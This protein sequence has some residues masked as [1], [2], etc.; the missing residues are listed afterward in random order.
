MKR[1]RNILVPLHFTKAD[2]AVVR[3]VS[4]FAAWCSPSSITFCHYSPREEI[5]E[6]LKES[7]PWLWEPIDEAALERLRKEVLGSGLFEDE[8]ILRF[9]VEEANPVSRSLERVLADDCDLVVTGGERRD[10]AVRLARKAPCSVC[11]VPAGSAENIR[12]AAVAVDFSH[13][14]R[15]ACEIGRALSDAMGSEEPV[16]LHVS[17]LHHGHRLGL[18]SS[19]ELI[20]A[21]ERHAR[22]R[23]RDFCLGLDAP[24]DP[25]RV[26]VHHHESV[27]Y[28]ILDYVSNN[29]I[30]C[31]VIGCR[32]RD[33]LSA[34]LLGSVAEEILTHANVPVLAVKTKGT[35]QGFLKTILGIDD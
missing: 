11:V 14:S 35:G 33:A 30:D 2:D 5:P 4:H 15:Y 23:L 32:G 7:H 1:F 22:L 21:N 31:L 12:R 28:G 16:L 29:G 20:A 9:E 18:L 19:E 25:E 34:L 27:A 8:S 10:I 13:Y 3:M 26:A 6:S 24:Q 17:Q